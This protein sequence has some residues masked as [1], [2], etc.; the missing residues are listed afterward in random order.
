MARVHADRFGFGDHAV[1]QPNRGPG[2]ARMM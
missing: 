2:C 1:A